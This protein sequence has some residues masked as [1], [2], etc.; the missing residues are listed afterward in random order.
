MRVGF[1]SRALVGLERLD[2]GDVMLLAL[3]DALAREWQADPAA[4]ARA[5]FAIDRVPLPVKALFALRQVGATVIGIRDRESESRSFVVDEVVDGEALIRT[6]APHLDFHVGVAVSD[7]LLRVTT[8]VALH[9]WRGR[10][11]F[12][13]VRIVH[14]P[15]L[16]A[17]M[18]AAV[19]RAT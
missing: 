2:H 15:V 14:A 12:A 4:A 17:M 8:A 19:R 7:G 16:L 13:P 11:Y 18:R 3:P 6:A 10:L 1:G 9:G 5:V